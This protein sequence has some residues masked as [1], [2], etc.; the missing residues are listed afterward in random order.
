MSTYISTRSLIRCF[1]SLLTLIFVSICL[2]LL[3]I[4]TFLTLR[5][6]LL[7]ISHLIIPISFGFPSSYNVQTTNSTSFP[8]YLVSSINLTDPMYDKTPLDI[9]HHSYRVELLCSSPYSYR[10]RQ[11]GSFFVQ[12]ILFSTRKEIIIEHSQ[13]ILFP[14]QSEIIR[15]IRVFIFLPLSIFNIDYN[16]WK[17]QKVLIERLINHEKSKN[18]IEIVQLNVIPSS[19]QLDQCSLHFHILDVTGLIYLYLKYPFLTGCFS[20]FFLFSIYMTFYLIIT[21]I[22]MLNQMSKSDKTK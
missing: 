15:L 9:S 3:S 19:F 17:F 18:F 10:N 13:L 11:L 7:P 1:Q 6:H 20:T 5:K 22:K 12:L 21:G 4:V 8:S 16:Q 2:F 14:Y